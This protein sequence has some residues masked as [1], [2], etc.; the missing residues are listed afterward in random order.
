[1]SKIKIVM[2]K[3]E[4]SINFE[5]EILSKLHNKFIV[6][7]YY[8]FQDK[9]N[10]YLV[11]DYLKGGDLRFHLTRH[12]RFSEEQSRFFIC[13]IITALEYIHS[14]NI[15]H[16]DIKP[17]NLVLE[18]EGYVRLTDFGIARKSMDNNKGDTSGTP[19]YMAP[20][21]MRGSLHSFEVDFFAIGIIGYEFLKGKR[22]YHGK[23]RK[24][25]REEM[26][27]KQISIKNEEIEEGWTKES[28]D[29][30]NRLL[31]RKK[32]NRLGYK[33]IE[34]I[35]EH[36]WIK[37]YPWTMI[38]DKTL[39]S[40]FVPQSKDN[41]DLRY[42]AKSD[43]IG[44][45]TKMRYE[46]IIM[47][48]ESKNFFNNF[49]F[50]YDYEQMVIQK[51]KERN[52]NNI[53]K[54][55]INKMFNR[56]Q[57]YKYDLNFYN[58]KASYKQLSNE[59]NNNKIIINN[60]RDKYNTI[61]EYN[62]NNNKKKNDL[63]NIEETLYSTIFKRE[64]LENIN[65]IFEHK[66]K[67]KNNNYID[68]K[69]NRNNSNI[70]SPNYN[71]IEKSLNNK[72][73]KRRINISGILSPARS[74]KYIFKN[75]EDNI[76]KIF[77]YQRQ[78]SI[79]F[80]SKGEINIKYLSNKSPSPSIHHKNEILIKKQI[81][82]INKFATLL[83]K[84]N[85]SRSKNTSKNK[86]MK[87]NYN[88]SKI[89][90][91]RIPYLN[92]NI[93]SSQFNSKN[94]FQSKKSNNAIVNNNN[95]NENNELL[96]LQNG[97]YVP[98]N[99]SRVYAK[100]NIVPKAKNS[101]AT[102]N[103]CTFNNSININRTFLKD[104]KTKENRKSSSKRS[105]KN[106]LTGNDKNNDSKKKILINNKKININDSLRSL[107]RC[108]SKYISLKDINTNKHQ[109]QGQ[110]AQN[111]LKTNINYYSNNNNNNNNSNNKNNNI[112]KENMNDNLIN[113]NRNNSIKTKQIINKNNNNNNNI[114]A[115]KERIFVN[116]R[117]KN[118]T[119]VLDMDKSKNVFNNNSINIHKNPFNLK[120]EK[121][122]SN[123]CTLNNSS[124]FKNNNNVIKGKD[125][126]NNYG[127]GNRYVVI[128]YKQK[129][130]F[131]GK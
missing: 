116:K 70:M 42:C 96:Y 104:F 30:I 126:D 69:N 101:M 128:S 113:N 35:K 45:E 124:S 91:N 130:N 24:E 100:D 106:I 87:Q 77:K 84:S 127:N 32:E 119:I 6:N 82:N 95:N 115:K 22:P 23:N 74:D 123:Y 34:E 61:N 129:Q 8:A 54:N 64:N 72:I 52:N 17:E 16:R 131:K 60:N 107:I 122:R 37:Y 19:G 49:Y 10:L 67:N 109:Q 20:E 14:K 102:N 73:Y 93:S 15:I 9:D 83:S 78:R 62:T 31:I 48:N 89:K 59:K 28:I 18:E 63:D 56:V 53:N 11:M 7:M 21:V 121:N 5:R 51:N 68:I 114:E 90:S 50:N 47:D 2:R 12:I 81:H 36:P 99:K 26:L 76:T 103:N 92:N 1:M 112:E 108:N 33:G 66:L 86:S 111:L 80:N 39:P 44:E 58:N 27:M 46:E 71:N 3:S 94:L 4:K 75:K 38:I 13:N 85:S 125:K 79:I 41:F 43:K 110:Q 118:K 65:K 25:I 40:P 105:N 98:K 88:Q 29:F 57:N 55:I 97:K 120:K 117:A